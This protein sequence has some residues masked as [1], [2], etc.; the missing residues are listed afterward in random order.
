MNEILYLRPSYRNLGIVGLL[1]FL[2]MMI[3]SVALSASGGRIVAACVFTAF[4]GFWVEMSVWILL[5]YWRGWLRIGQGPMTEKGVIRT[6]AMSISEIVRLR[7]R[8]S[9]AIVLRSSSTR[10][11]LDAN[12]FSTRN[13][14][15]SSCSCRPGRSSSKPPVDLTGHT[16]ISLRLPSFRQNSPPANR[17]GRSVASS[18]PVAVRRA[19]N[20]LTQCPCSSRDWTDQLW[21]RQDRCR[22]T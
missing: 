21:Y 12:P 8:L 16:P 11:G 2:G 7:W 4:G 14:P 18:L 1:F 13:R 17:R 3:M 19:R 5:T 6:K 22:R 10:I 9:R 15:L 20:V